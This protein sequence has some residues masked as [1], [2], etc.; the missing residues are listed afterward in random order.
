MVS[1]FQV[2]LKVLAGRFGIAFCCWCT[3]DEYS[4]HVVK[5]VGSKNWLQILQYCGY[6]DM[7][8]DMG[9]ADESHDGCDVP[10]VI[11]CAG[12]CHVFPILPNYFGCFPVFLKSN[13]RSEI[14]GL[15]LLP[16]LLELPCPEGCF[17]EGFGGFSGQ[18]S[19]F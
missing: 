16:Q 5:N 1:V 9:S 3:G 13:E 19:A 18:K 15:V 17:L 6:V 12:G 2:G 10:I 4:L 8:I 14:N 11:Q 7:G